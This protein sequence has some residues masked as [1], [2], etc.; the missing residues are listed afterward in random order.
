MYII[1]GD[2]SFHERDERRRDARDARDARRHRGRS[3][4]PRAYLFRFFA[5]LSFSFSS[6]AARRR[7][8]DAREGT[9]TNDVEDPAGSLTE[10]LRTIEDGRSRSRER[11]RAARRVEA[12]AMDTSSISKTTTTGVTLD[13]ERAGRRLAERLV[14]GRE[15]SEEVREAFM[16]AMVAAMVASG[17]GKDLIVID[18]EVLRALAL[19][20][21]DSCGKVA[22]AS[23]RGVSALCRIA[24]EDSRSKVITRALAAAL[25]HKTGKVRQEAVRQL[26]SAL[27]E[28]DCFH[29]VYEL[30]GG[31]HVDVST[32][33]INHFSALACDPSPFV[34]MEFTRL[35]G[36]CL[37]GASVSLAPRILPYIL[38]SLVDEIIDVVEVAKR[39][40]QSR[41]NFRETVCR[42]LGDVLLPALSELRSHIESNWRVDVMLRILDLIEAL[43]VFAKDRATQF[44]PN[45]M[46]GL[47]EAASS[48]SDT[49]VQMKARAVR[50]RFKHVCPEAYN[51][52]I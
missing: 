38:S 48:T 52:K 41:R 35:C 32:V 17:V 50:E 42:H 30:T 12:W 40:I 28:S 4:R 3:D 29:L 27:C 1:P 34:R 19:G 26:E 31:S 16:D 21:K 39:I 13:W 37:D 33:R 5:S 6:R 10:A 7:A 51:Y 14:D 47:D 24:R 44:I 22:M 9:R 11:E 23:A 2:G 20:A 18:D 45:I 36:A 49:L 8:M 15:T 25:T 43:V 46:D